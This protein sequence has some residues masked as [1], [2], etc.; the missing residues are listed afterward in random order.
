[1]V[2]YYAGDLG[3]VAIPSSAGFKLVDAK[4]GPGLSAAHYPE[5]GLWLHL[6]PAALPEGV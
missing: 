4:L 1:M 2:G 5:V 6:Q 3:E